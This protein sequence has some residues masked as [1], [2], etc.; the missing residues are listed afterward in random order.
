MDARVEG[1]GV[2]HRS[3]GGRQLEHDFRQQPLQPGARRLHVRE[4]RLHA[5]RGAGRRA[6]DRARADAEHADLHRR[7]AQRRAVP[8]GQRVR[9]QRDLH[10]VHPAVG[11]RRPRREDGRAVHLLADRAARSDRHERPLLVRDRQRVPASS[12]IKMPTD[13]AVFFVQD[14][15][16]RQNL[17][18]NLGIRYD[19]EVTRIDNGFNP[20]FA[21]NAYATDK[22]N[23]APRLGFSYKPAGSNVS[24]IRGGYGIFYDKVTLQTTTPFVSTGVYSSSFTTQFPL[25]SADPG[26]SRGQL[27]I[28]PMLVNGPVL[29]RALIN[30]QFPP[31][32]IGR[33]IG[34]VFL[35]NPDRVVPNVHQV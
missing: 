32:S 21:K 30:A 25:S 12:D 16:Q 28:D 1:S 6:D 33:N 3:D 2:R 8:H 19:L 24:L 31:G 9:S 14:K 35:D 11:R 27:P 7:H 20:L 15:W 29:N 22:N 10:T 17:T 18:L 4:E 23:F 13:V 34:Q 26:P 5:E